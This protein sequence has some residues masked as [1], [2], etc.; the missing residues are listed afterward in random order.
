MNLFDRYEEE[1][2]LGSGA[3]GIVYK[4]KDRFTDLPVALKRIPLQEYDEGI[5]SSTIREMA[6][7][8]ELRHPNIIA[9]HHFL[10]AHPPALFDH[11]S[12]QPLLLCSYFPSSSSSFLSSLPNKQTGRYLCLGEIRDA[13][14]Q[15]HGLGSEKNARFLSRRTRIG[16][17]QDLA[18]PA[19]RRH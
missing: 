2:K 9:Y 15:V 17:G 18:L 6:L 8:C 11:P 16:N 1:E 10:T 4:A 3:Y 12:T 13:C 7:L 5:S 19:P 14:V